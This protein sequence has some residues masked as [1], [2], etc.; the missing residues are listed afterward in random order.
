M[1]TG[2]S[3]SP[4]ADPCRTLKLTTLSHRRVAVVEGV[5]FWEQPVVTQ[6]Q[7]L[8]CCQEIPGMR[9]PLDNSRISSL[10]F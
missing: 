4:R 3:T 1:P 10:I 5:G 6:G 2:R 9:G 8:C 7:N